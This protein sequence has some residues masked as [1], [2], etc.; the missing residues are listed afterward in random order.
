MH[1]RFERVHIIERVGFGAKRAPADLAA[2]GGRHGIGGALSVE[3]V[4]S[5]EISFCEHRILFP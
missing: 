1:Q 4:V 2:E 3:F 5:V